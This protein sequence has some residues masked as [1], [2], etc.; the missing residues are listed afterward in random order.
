[1]THEGAEAD[2]QSTPVQANFGIMFV[3]L[4]GQMTALGQHHPIT[5]EELNRNFEYIAHAGP[6]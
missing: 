2:M 5:H 1:M 4:A 3:S 6:E